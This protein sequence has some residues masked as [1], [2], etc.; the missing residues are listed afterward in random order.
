MAVDFPLTNQDL[1]N[2][3]A[4][5]YG[6]MGSEDINHWQMAASAFFNRLGQRE[7]ASLSP[8]EV[9]ESGFYAVSNKNDPYTW[10]ISKKFPNKQEED[11]FK[12]IFALVNAMVRGKKEILPNQFFFTKKEI[13]SLKRKKKFNF[14]QVEP[15]GKIGKYHLFKYKE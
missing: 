12:E 5:V 2:I 10:A 4:M 15:V 7:W 14:N 11:R 8:M 6:E 13:N 3:A 9:L 1:Y